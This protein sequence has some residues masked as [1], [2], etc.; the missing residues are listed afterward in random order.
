MSPKD[1][2]EKVYYEDSHAK[3]TNVRITCNNLTAPLE[4]IGSVNINYKT[5]KFAASIVCLVL[6]CSPFLFYPLLP[7]NLKLPISV[8]ALVFIIASA[9]FVYFN[10]IHYVELILSVTGRRIN[11][12]STGMLNKQYLEEICMKISD[13]ILDEKKYQG[14]KD[15]GELESSLKL[16][17]SETMRLKMVLEDY[18]ELKKMKEEFSLQKK[19]EKK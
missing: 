6:A 12:M 1:M 14:L 5:E 13:A 15:S 10:Y 3:V 17:P 2:S 11:L 9:I 4:K 7:D 16:N 8:I 18:E 19:K